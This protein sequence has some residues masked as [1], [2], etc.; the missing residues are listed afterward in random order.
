L[1][2]YHYP[3]TGHDGYRVVSCGDDVE[4]ITLFNAHPGETALVVTDVDMPRAGGV[5]LARA[6]LQLHPDLR[7][8]A[9]SGLSRR[10]TD[11]ADVPEIQK[12]AHAFLRKP[13]TT[14]NLLGTV[15][16]LLQPPGKT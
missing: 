14:E 15:H 1:K 13:F 8:L 16:R 12:L 3:E 5:A 7:L 10:E 4:A 6:L 9:M 2:L 11:G